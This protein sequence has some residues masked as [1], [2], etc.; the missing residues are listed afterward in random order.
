MTTCGKQARKQ[1][2]MNKAQL[3]RATHTPMS[4]ESRI[5]KGG[6]YVSGRKT[7]G[8]MKADQGATVAR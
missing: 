5:R 4:A 1:T 6:K 2:G 8:Q 7:R 3:K